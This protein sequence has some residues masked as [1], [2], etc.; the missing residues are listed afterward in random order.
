MGSLGKNGMI[1]AVFEY[2]KEIVQR[3][4]TIPLHLGEPDENKRSFAGLTKLRNR[5]SV[6]FSK[7]YKIQLVVPNKFLRF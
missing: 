3:I 6:P 2:D 4:Q 5:G 7:P 1:A